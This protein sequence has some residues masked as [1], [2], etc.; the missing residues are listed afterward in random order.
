MGADSCELLCPVHEPAKSKPVLFWKLQSCISE[1]LCPSVYLA[2]LWQSFQVWAGSCLSCLEGEQECSCLAP[3][4]IW[5]GIFLAAAQTLAP[6]TFLFQHLQWVSLTSVQLLCYF[7]FLVPGIFF[8]PF[9]SFF[10]LLSLQARLS[11]SP[12]TLLKAVYITCEPRAITG[13]PPC[14]GGAQLCVHKGA[15]S[16]SMQ[17]LWLK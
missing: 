10:Q 8:F 14:S 16:W 15:E 5:K 6:A 1:M 17:N 13:V 2:P 3:S 12:S 7:I 9:F 11:V 4:F